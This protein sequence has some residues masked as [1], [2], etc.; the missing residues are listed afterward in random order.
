MKESW[1]K[2]GTKLKIKEI[3]DLLL[4]LPRSSSVSI[5]SAEHLHKELFT[6]SGAGTLIRRGH[7][8]NKYNNLDSINIDRLRMLLS[9][10]DPEIRSGGASVAK[11]LQKITEHKVSMYGDEGFE[12]FAVVIEDESNSIPILDRLIATQSA[13][14]NNV[15][16][17][18]WQII[19]QQFPSLIWSIDKKDPNRSWY[20]ERSDGSITQD[21]K[22]IFWY[23]VE[24]LNIVRKMGQE[25][26]QM[27]LGGGGG[28][29]GGGGGVRHY[30]TSVHPKKI[31]YNN[32]NR[33]NRRQSG[34]SHSIQK[35]A[36][37]G[38]L[39][40]SNF[41]NLDKQINSS[42][43][44]LFS[45]Y[46]ATTTTTTTTTGTTP[47][48]TGVNSQ[49]SVARIGLIGARGHTGKEL[50]KLIDSHPSMELAY[51]SSRELQGKPC[52]DYTS[53]E[54]I[55]S[56]LS[57]SD[58]Q[59]IRHV[60]SWIMALP[61]G[62]CEPFVQSILNGCKT[63]K[64]KT[65]II[66]DL[67]ADYRFTNEWI[68][69]LPELKNRIPLQHATKISNPGCYATGSQLSIAPL[70]ESGLVNTLCGATIFGVSGYSG[71][72]TTPSP[73]N[74]VNHLKDNFLPYSLTDHIHEREISHHLQ[75]PIAFMPH[76]A[77]HFRGITITASI[78]LTKT[79]TSKEIRDL[80]LERYRGEKLIRISRE[81]DIPEVKEVQG[82]HYVNL[83]GFKVHSGGKRVVVVGTIDNLLKGAATQG[84][85]VRRFL[86]VI[87]LNPYFFF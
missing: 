22:T 6:H 80:Y 50:I 39:L 53:S 40:C 70:C 49:P 67:S 30:S 20:F 62:V 64:G 86:I 23:G 7:K 33:I 82:K 73:K 63:R 36:F 57:P 52:T 59:E 5:I 60:D 74:D 15:P 24:D 77:P 31:I 58:L 34:L 17:N 25:L 47:S 11:Y 55:Y 72:G 32:N 38:G 18:V 37:A 12:V 13:T 87:F 65:P 16:D 85:Q 69:G 10:C 35:R 8:I 21:G 61:N 81:G 83:G 56:N 2:Y 26:S 48:S 1:V 43:S 9:D 66:L 28:G 79:M 71:A 41:F 19:R 14:L 51:V 84:I 3:R 4:H 54:V 29:R 78:P 42:S 68:Y 75:L 76:V 46:F 27:S 44:S 45:R